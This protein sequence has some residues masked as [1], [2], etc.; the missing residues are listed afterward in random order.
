M[1]WPY[2]KKK[3]LVMLIPVHNKLASTVALEILEDIRLKQ[4]LEY[5]LRLIFIVPLFGY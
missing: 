2:E 3:R 1:I 4:I 5:A